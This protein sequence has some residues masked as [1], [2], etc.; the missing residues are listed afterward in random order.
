[1]AEIY[2]PKGSHALTTYLV[3]TDGESLIFFVK[4]VFHAKEVL[5]QSGGGGGTHVELIIGD[6]NLM[7][8]IAAGAFEP[9]RAMFYTYVPDVDAA[10]RRAIEL[11]AASL[12]VPTDET[13]GDRRAGFADPFG[14]MWYVASRIKKSGNS[15]A[16]RSSV[17]GR[18]KTTRKRKI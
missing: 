15:T 8:G 4:N 10:Y 11:G 12:Q 6:S 14:N 2:I 13:Y 18:M 7:V 16:R 9:I 17:K 3:P 5:R 1:M